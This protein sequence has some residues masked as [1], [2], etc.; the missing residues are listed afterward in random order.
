M[1]R[2]SARSGVILIITAA[3]A[4]ILATLCLTFIA[5]ANN[6]GADSAWIGRYTQ[7]RVML[8]AGLSYVQECARIGWDTRLG[9]GDN[10]EGFGWVD[11]RGG[12]RDRARFVTVHGRNPSGA[13]AAAFPLGPRSQFDRE[14]ED[15]T[16]LAGG[17]GIWD[18]LWDPALVEDGDGDGL[19]DRPAWPAV[20]SVARAPMFR[21]RRPPFAIEPVVAPNPIANNPAD[22]AFGLPLLLHPDPLPAFGRG[23]AGGAPATRWADWSAGE[24]SALPGSEGRAWFRVYRDGPATF[25]VT[26]G[27]GGSEGFRDW[28][29]VL[30]AQAEDLFQRD[31][32]MFEDIVANEV[33]L[34]YRIEWSPAVNGNE[35]QTIGWNGS[36][37]SVVTGGKPDHVSK[38]PWA[39]IVNQGG[40]IQWIQ[41]LRAPPELW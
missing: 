36:Q 27:C 1:N 29:E 32:R 20:G 25:V 18:R 22:P 5:R 24:R 21:M 33:R 28:P 8:H 19:A 6:A 13:E 38:W 17:D 39:R 4:A 7:A 40:T 37:L 3:L 34:W 12:I 9:D 26:C 2:S 23:V 11:V 16:A 10:H 30:G 31:Q 14:G 15:G 35:P 41:R